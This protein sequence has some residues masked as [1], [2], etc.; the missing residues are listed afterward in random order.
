MRR[1]RRSMDSG[2]SIPT[3][4]DVTPLGAAELKGEKANTRIKSFFCHIEANRASF[5][6][7]EVI[8]PPHGLLHILKARRR[9]Q[10]FLL[11]GGHRLFVV[12]RIVRLALALLFALLLTA[13]ALVTLKHA[14]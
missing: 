5:F 8:P 3:P 1:L 12:T 4:S 10:P 11:G 7:M 2:V 13:G 6:G 14:P 9:L